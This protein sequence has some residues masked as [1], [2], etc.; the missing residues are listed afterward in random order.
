MSPHDCLCK[1]SKILAVFSK[2]F[3]FEKFFIYVLPKFNSKLICAGCYLYLL[4][5]NLTQDVYNGIFSNVNNKIN[6]PNV[7]N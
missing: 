2:V 6:V 7:R 5:E 3:S 1:V 4:I